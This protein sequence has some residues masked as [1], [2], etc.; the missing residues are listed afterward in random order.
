MSNAHSQGRAELAHARAVLAELIALLGGAQAPQ[1]GPVI[2]A[3]GELQIRSD[4]A[5]ALLAEAAG[6]PAQTLGFRL[7]AAEAARLA[8]RLLVELVGHRARRQLPDAAEEP[9]LSQRRRLGEHYLN[10]TAL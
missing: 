7:A 4:A 3:V 6:S 2:A 10:G 1:E 5:S 8:D 9:L